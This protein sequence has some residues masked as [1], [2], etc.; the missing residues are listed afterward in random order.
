MIAMMIAMMM[1]IVV[2]II[3]ILDVE[4]IPKNFLSSTDIMDFCWIFLAFFFHYWSSMVILLLLLL[5]VDSF[6]TN[7]IIHFHLIVSIRSNWLTNCKYYDHH[8]GLL[9]YNNNNF[10]NNNNNVEFVFQNWIS[11]FP[12]PQEKNIIV[13]II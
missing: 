2:D 5:F 4:N 10:P 12:A 8:H 13:I 6:Q 1:V 9:I 3:V 7:Q 11:D